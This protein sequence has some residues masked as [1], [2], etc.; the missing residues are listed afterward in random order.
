M[1]KFIIA[2]M[3][4]F[5][6]TSVLFSQNWFVG[7]SMNLGFTNDSRDES[8][9][10]KEFENRYINISPEI[11]YRFS[12]FDFG[13]RPIFQYNYLNSDE[14]Y[15][16]SQYKTNDSI[17]GFGAG[18]FTRLHIVTFFDRLSFLGR[19]DLDYVF[20]KSQMEYEMN[21]ET[22]NT[23]EAIN[24]NIG[25]RFTPIAEFRLTERFSLYSSIIGSIISI[26]Y[27]NS[28]ETADYLYGGEASRERNS[29]YLTLPSI[30]KFSLTDISF[31]FYLKF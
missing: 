9:R 15:F 22:H 18:V 23:I 28:S 27:L 5:G 20:S 25:L 1:K 17:L 3:F 4:V 19:F 8:N 12:N 26:G 13:I 29:L 14:T 24:H 31:G 10:S 6:I 2:V 16:S 30:Y 7:G 11:G 21:T